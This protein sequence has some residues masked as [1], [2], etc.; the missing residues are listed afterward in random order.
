MDT[1][2]I[3]S[4]VVDG[5]VA[6]VVYFLVAWAKK[7]VDRLFMMFSGDEKSLIGTV[8][9]FFVDVAQSTNSLRITVKD[10]LN[11]SAIKKTNDLVD[12]IVEGLKVFA[13]NIG[14]HTAAV[15]DTVFGKKGEQRSWRVAGALIQLLFLALFVYADISQGYNSLTGAEVFEDLDIPEAF[16]SLAI[17]ILVSSIGSIAALS[18]VLFDLYGMTHFIPWEWLWDVWTKRYGKESM[19]R[20][21]K[22]LIKIVITTMVVAPIFGLMI[23][24]GRI[25]SFVEVSEA[26][27]KFIDL[28][29][30]I[31]QWLIMLP[32]LVTTIFLM[33]GVT[34]L[35]LVYSLILNFF[36]VV[37]WV[38]ALLLRV[39]DVVLRVIGFVIGVLIEI[40]SFIVEK[41]FVLLASLIK[42]IR[43]IIEVIYIIINLLV[44]PARKIFKI[45]DEDFPSSQYPDKKI[46]TNSNLTPPS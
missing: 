40:L 36:R 5:L 8:N 11:E 12:T 46:H 44:S 22:S 9:V 30:G 25:T 45:D 4:T 13:G 20:F 39:L 17:P 21:R 2:N 23:S 42:L 41:L 1:S 14:D 37:P 32:M 33:W 6:L 3:L 43:I 19:E 24:M 10:F 34:S 31:A 18:L 35:L 27:Q 29:V 15:I 26:F 16:Q 28:M 7:H 38:V